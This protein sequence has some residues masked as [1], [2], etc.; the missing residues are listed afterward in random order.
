MF[1][2]A[3][4]IVACPL[5]WWT[6]RSVRC[7]FESPIRSLNT[8]NNPSLPNPRCRF[9]EYKPLCRYR[10]S[11]ASSSS[12]SVAAW[13]K[14]SR[15]SETPPGG[16]RKGWPTLKADWCK[17]QTSWG[18]TTGRDRK[19]RCQYSESE[20][21]FW[22]WGR[23]DASPKLFVMAT[24]AKPVVLNLFSVTPPMSNCPLFQVPVTLTE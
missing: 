13:R 15:G 12:W 18:C 20:F 23:S 5:Q 24:A 11:T 6:W 4:S 19:T 17:Y 10:E 16:R 14:W 21:V 8:R 3:I 1:E 2:R 9:L 7:V 22:S